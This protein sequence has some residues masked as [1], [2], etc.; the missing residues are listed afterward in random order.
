MD[1][2]HAGEAAIVEQGRHRLVR[3]QHE[4]LDQPLGVPA[5][6]ERHV[7]RIAALVQNE[8]RFGSVER[9]GAAGGAPTFEH[10]AEFPHP[11][12]RG[13]DRAVFLVERG[14]LPER[15]ER[16]DLGIHAAY[17]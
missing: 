3:R 9:E 7:D 15:E 13:V 17:A 1:P 5:R 14:R 12:K 16:V 6:A 2:V 4:L 10:A 8:D 11:G